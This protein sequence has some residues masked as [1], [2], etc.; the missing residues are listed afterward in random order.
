MNNNLY[1]RLAKQQLCTFKFS[2][3]HC[4]AELKKQDE[5]ENY[6]YIFTEMVDNEQ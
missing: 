4:S 1:V 2:K 5:N 3:G 6:I